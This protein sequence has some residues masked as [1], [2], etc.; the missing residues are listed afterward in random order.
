MMDDITCQKAY[1]NPILASQQQ[2]DVASFQPVDYFHQATRMM[3]VPM[4]ESISRSA[5][6][7][8]IRVLTA[9]AQAVLATIASWLAES[10][11]RRGLGSVDSHQV[12][13]C[14]TAARVNTSA[15]DL[16]VGSAATEHPQLASGEQ[17]FRPPTPGAIGGPPHPKQRGPEHIFS[18][19]TRDAQKLNEQISI[20]IESIELITSFDAFAMLKTHQPI[21]EIA[22]TASYLMRKEQFNR[23]QIFV[24]AILKSSN[25]ENIN[26]CKKKL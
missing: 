10:Q 1:T 4:Q 13:A 11:E 7:Q 20:N 6:T 8:Q 18:S 16:A 19:A 12:D 21:T 14:T 2:A 3:P 25:C 17:K 5:S 26:E 22:K 9:D 15:G 24:F 23:N